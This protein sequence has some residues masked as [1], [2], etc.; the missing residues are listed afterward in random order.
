MCLTTLN[1]LFLL[2]L[3]KTPRPKG[4]L[5]IRVRFY[6]T[7]S[8]DL[9]KPTTDGKHKRDKGNPKYTMEYRAN[10]TLTPFQ[11]EALMGLLLG[12]SHISKRLSVKGWPRLTIRHS[13]DQ[14]YYLQHLHELFEPTIVQPLAIG[15]TFDSRTNKSYYWCNL[16][17]LYLKCFAYYRSLF[18]NQAGVKIIPANIGEVLTSVG[19]AYWFADDGY[20]HMSTGGCYLSTNSFTLAEVVL[21]VEV[22]KK[23][24]DL[25]CKAHKCGFKDQRVLYIFPSQ[26]DKFRVLVCPYLHNTLVYKLGL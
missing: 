24:F 12:D 8:D 16:H 26:V 14:F 1:L 13:M 15:S 3:K 9:S 11:S 23:N 4:K 20:F 18:Y 6:S 5:P 21:L 22:L 10:L 2:H 17:T 7:S 25:D 19:L